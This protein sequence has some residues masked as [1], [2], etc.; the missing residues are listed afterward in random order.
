MG[1]AIGGVIANWFGVLIIYINSLQDELYGI[2]LPIACIFALISTVGILFAGK[3]KKLAGTLIIT[4]SILFVP[5]G[6]IGV[7]GAKK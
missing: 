5:L 6:L 4:G 3:N 7:F 2:M 1:L